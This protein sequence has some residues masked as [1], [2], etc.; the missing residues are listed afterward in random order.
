M[1]ANV[2]FSTLSKHCTSWVSQ[3]STRESFC[4]RP[5]KLAHR[6]RQARVILFFGCLG[7]ILYPGC[8]S[9]GSSV[10]EDS[11]AV[12]KANEELQHQVEVAKIYY[13]NRYYEKVESTLVEALKNSSAT[14]RAQAEEML[15]SALAKLGREEPVE[16]ESPQSS[17]SETEEDTDK[18]IEALLAK[19]DPSDL[20]PEKNK[21][22]HPATTPMPTVPTPTAPIPTVGPTPMKSPPQ[23]VVDEL[24]VSVEL[25]S[26]PQ[27][28]QP[29]TK[30]LI[31]ALE[32]QAKRAKTA[33]EAS[34]MYV[35]FASFFTLSGDE[36][37]LFEQHQLN[38]KAKAKDG[39]VRYGLKWV[40]PEKVTD[41]ELK[42]QHLLE[43]AIGYI[44][45][46]E[47]DKA[48]RSLKSASRNDMNSVRADYLLGM[49]NSM[50][51]FNDPREAQ[52]HFRIAFNRDSENVSLLNNLALSEFKV[53]E[54]ADAFAHWK[55]AVE[56]A[57][58]TP[59]LS[60]NLGRILHDCDQEINGNRKLVLGVFKEKHL[61]LYQATQL[62]GAPKHNSGVGWLY[63]PLVTKDVGTFAPSVQKKEQRMFERNRGSGVV[64]RPGYV[65]T[66][67]YIIDDNKLGRTH[68]IQ[69]AMNNKPYSAELLVVSG[70]VV[71][72]HVPNLPVR[73]VVSSRALPEPGLNL[74]VAGYR[75]RMNSQAPVTVPAKPLGQ[76][77]L[78]GQQQL[79]FSVPDV[80]DFVGGV[81]SSATGEMA[82]ML[83][84]PVSSTGAISLNGREGYSYAV[85]AA[86]IERMVEKHLGPMTVEPNQASFTK[87][88][89]QDSIV[90][91]QAM[92]RDVSFGLGDLA[93]NDF[94]ATGNYLEDMTCTHCNGIARVRCP[95]N[96]CKNGVIPYTKIVT[97]KARDGRVINTPTPASKKCSTCNGAGTIRCIFCDSGR[98]KSL[99]G[100]RR[101]AIGT[102]YERD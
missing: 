89:I 41:A 25:S 47:F 18:P 44:S 78:A 85:P 33:E 70:D 84:R 48:A 5:E 2:A 90:L 40:E 15:A 57:P 100:Y 63:M 46:Q 75:S 29:A 102:D 66:S 93:A 14:E 96:D 52:K 35:E 9:P 51:G 22:D 69:I 82:A 11:S 23:P 53:G 24:P 99:S 80:N 16:K 28:Q 79:V 42:G 56:L 45:R 101:S 67:R 68:Q 95:R 27:A 81:A 20:K 21:L 38:W 74:N 50:I 8:S 91:V 54:Y 19:A 55:R 6:L 1:R 64:V 94:Q 65:V 60:Q 49:F 61:D 98:D 3:F 62:A 71:L 59:E 17:D 72:L 37:K 32:K 58:T 10:P 39:L 77:P 34:E 4:F 36:K 86:S 7:M 97:R 26:L 73:P 88:K 43:Q 92:M 31:D 83:T 87:G 30:A 12:E 13:E 76:S